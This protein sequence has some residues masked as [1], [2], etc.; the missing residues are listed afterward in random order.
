[1]RRRIGS[2]ISGTCLLGIALL[3]VVGLPGA[4]R[5]QLARLPA[6]PNAPKLLV[7]P[8]GRDQVG[9]SG[10]A[11]TI[12]DA[13][14]Q[15]MLDAHTDAFQ[16]ITRDAVCRFLQES[17]FPCT[18]ALDPSQI[19]QLAHV[20][21]A[22]YM[23]D[24]VIFP[25]G[26]DSVLVMGRLLQNVRT[27][28]IAASA[29]IVEARDKVGDRT[30]RALADRLADKSRSFD[31]TTE[32]R[33]QLEAKDYGKAVDAA[34]RALRYDHESAGA[35]LCL[36]QVREAQGAPTDSV[37]AALEAAHDA[38][39]L[40]TI[41]GRQLFIIFQD[42]HDTTQM[43][44]MLRDIMR[45]DVNDVD[46]RKMAVELEV[47]RGHPDSA[48]MIL[49][50]ALARNPNQFDLQ[51]L[52][53]I[54]LGVEGKYDEAGAAMTAAG[55]AD[56]TKIDSLFLARTLAFYDAA[57]DTTNAMKWRRVC[58]VRTPT[59]SDCWFRYASGLYDQHD[60][61]GAISA[62]RHF[63]ELRPETGRA[64][65][66]LASY[67]AAAEQTDSALAEADAAVAADSAW[68]AAAAAAADAARRAVPATDSAAA[69]HAADSAW[70]ARMPAGADSLW[71][72]RAA[73]AAIHLRA[74][75]AAFQAQDWQKTLQLLM[76]AQPW[77]TDQA[78]VTIAY[79]IGNA[80]FNLGLPALQTLQAYKV[81][82]HRQATVDSACALIKAVT[83][84]FTPA[85]ANISAGAA[86]NRDGANQILTYIG[87]VTTALAPMKTR[88]KCAP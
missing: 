44:R 37:L 64:Q 43:L 84:A 14:R 27:N 63:V 54:A 42:R 83:D 67:F 65:T 49:N 58:T 50:M 74:G 25:H 61:T 69:A 38:D 16:T 28:P 24:G 36:A 70:H 17:G 31:H 8:F 71:S 45:V 77:A 20:M 51:V 5:A 82:M 32:C 47:R 79:L 78:A 60:T 29:T 6:S 76:P 66:A 85:Q 53:A 75:Y 46:I 80:Q 55:A 86:I 40:N 21:N 15:R 39:S 1:M 26:Q 3:G 72:P 9:D 30:G 33:N 35:Y 59:N 7:A 88:L 34:N 73:A 41:V 2:L 22:R 11:V 12:G 62:M 87:N 56:T 4:L 10:L 23:V 13:V 81:N 52:K 19:G 57:N 18:A 48:V 68:R